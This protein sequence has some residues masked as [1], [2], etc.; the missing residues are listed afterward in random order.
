MP[1]P[2][3]VADKLFALVTRVGEQAVVTG[4]AVGTVI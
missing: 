1:H 3:V 4:D 2:R